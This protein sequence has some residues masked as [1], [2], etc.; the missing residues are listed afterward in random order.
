MSARQKGSKSGFNA[1]WIVVLGLSILFLGAMLFWTLEHT[2]I[3]AFV[4]VLLLATSL[5]AFLTFWLL[6]STAISENKIDDQ[7]ADNRLL[8]TLVSAKMAKLPDLLRR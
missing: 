3:V 7:Q 4:T 2:D 5:E 6:K 1:L 8:V